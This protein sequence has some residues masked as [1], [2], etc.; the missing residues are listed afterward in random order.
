MPVPNM[1]SDRYC[2][3]GILSREGGFMIPTNVGQA[4]EVLEFLILFM[5]CSRY[6]V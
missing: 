3:D 1:F 2:E 4:F 5:R 6:P